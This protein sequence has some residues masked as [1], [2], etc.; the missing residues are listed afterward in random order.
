MAE[1]SRA[2]MFTSR[3][4]RVADVRASDWLGS[5]AAAKS[6]TALSVLRLH[7]QQPNIARTRHGARGRLS[8]LVR[9]REGR[10]NRPRSSARQSRPR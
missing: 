1:N 7:A 5:P 8:S 3:W 9:V 10:R 2:P 4:R 6:V